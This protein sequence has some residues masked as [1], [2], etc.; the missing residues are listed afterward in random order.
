MSD[1]ERAVDLLHSG[2]YTIVII[3]GEDIITDTARGVAPLLSLIDR[4]ISL[5]GA[6]AADKVVGRAAAMLFSLT[7]IK[8]LHTDVISAPAVKFLRGTDIN[9]SYGEITE[10][11]I[12]R[13][14]DGQ[15]PM[16]L[17]VTDISDAVE[18]LAAIRKRIN[19]LRKDN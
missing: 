3:N 9:F 13:K 10:Y 6:S 18:G 5:E 7:G 17:A 15:C 12:N 8:W 2:G 19:E 14:G 4:G 1:I 16:E 11:I